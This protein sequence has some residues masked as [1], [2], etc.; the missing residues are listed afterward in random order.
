M[1]IQLQNGSE[2]TDVKRALSG[3]ELTSVASLPF[4]S[5][6]IA[7]AGAASVSMRRIVQREL[8]VSEN[9]CC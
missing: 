4:C 1:I 5:G 3:C 9:E 6:V 2:A 8:T 7:H